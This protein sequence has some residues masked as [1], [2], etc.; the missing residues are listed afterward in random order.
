MNLGIF[1]KNSLL[2]Y[3]IKNNDSHID[4][5]KENDANQTMTE[6]DNERAPI[7]LDT[8]VGAQKTIAFRHEKVVEEF[9]NLL[10]DLAGRKAAS[11][12]EGKQIAKAV[13]D[14]AKNAGVDL[15]RDGFH[16]S[17][18]YQKK[19]LFEARTIDTER[20][21]ICS[22]KFFPQLHASSKLLESENLSEQ[23]NTTVSVSELKPTSIEKKA[24]N[25]RS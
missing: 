11:P 6:Q 5:L 8:I 24:E 17:L 2:H 9:Q 7:Q 19:G 3:G 12:E 25:L 10:D 13:Y 1:D 18:R 4:G 20:K 22:G 15:L 23:T 16:V 14:I 21:H